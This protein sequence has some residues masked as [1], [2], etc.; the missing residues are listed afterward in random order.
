MLAL[1]L[2]ADP[3]VAVRQQHFTNGSVAFEVD[4]LLL[5]PPAAALQAAGQAEEQG[6][7]LL[8]LTSPEGGQ[9]WTAEQAVNLGPAGQAGACD[10]EQPADEAAQGGA[11]AAVPQ[12]VR[13]TLRVLVEQ[14]RLWWPHDFGRQPLYSLRV[15]YTP[16]LQAGSSSEGGGSAAS[17][18]AEAGPAPASEPSGAAT[19]GGRAGGASDS[20]GSGSMVSR[21]IGLRRV[22]LVAEPLP[23]GSGETFF[24][25]VNGQPVYARGAELQG[26]RAQQGMEG[27]HSTAIAGRHDSASP[28]PAA[29]SA[30]RHCLCCWTASDQSFHCFSGTCRCQRGASPSV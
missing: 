6:K 17:P 7:L 9:Q 14:P 5:P 4:A 27:G 19:D 18:A 30:L 20:S 10:A 1:T 15:T 24:F 8:E 25:R 16:G 29:S 13:G 21:R 28:A 23:G 26:K 11:A 2:P 3:G 22:E 12:P